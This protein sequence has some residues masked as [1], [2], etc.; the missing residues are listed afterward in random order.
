MAASTQDLYGID[1]QE[2]RDMTYAQALEH[3]QNALWLRHNQ[4]YSEIQTL[5]VDKSSYEERV[6]L[7]A[8]LR[9]IKKAL[10]FNEQMLEEIA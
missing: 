5:P 1:P 2:L 8:D 4:V 9:R 10:A 6:A 7:E 3:K